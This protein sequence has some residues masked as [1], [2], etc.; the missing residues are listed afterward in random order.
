MAQAEHLP[1]YKAGYDLCLHLEEVVSRFGRTHR[2]GLGA[3]LREAVEELKVLCRLGPDVEALEASSPPPVAARQTVN[4]GAPRAA[5]RVPSGSE[6]SARPR[7]PCRLS[8]TPPYAAG[9]PACTCQTPGRRLHGRSE[10]PGGTTVPWMCTPHRWDPALRI[11]R[12]P[13]KPR[14]GSDPTQASRKPPTTNRCSIPL[15]TIRRDTSRAPAVSLTPRR[16]S[17]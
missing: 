4:V 10:K 8:V 13:M 6:V 14:R 5:G 15:S 1:T 2:Y 3:E 9:T 7:A 12:Y 16:G 17:Q 11:G